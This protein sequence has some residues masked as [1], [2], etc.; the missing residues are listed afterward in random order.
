[1]NPS[2]F[3]VIVSWLSGLH[4]VGQGAT[5]RTATEGIIQPVIDDKQCGR[6]L[7]NANFKDSTASM[8]FATVFALFS[9]ILNAAK[10][11]RRN[12]QNK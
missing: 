5:T 12:Q 7:S 8:V 11:A 4:G 3:A 6:K 10:L 9:V 1:M 2:I